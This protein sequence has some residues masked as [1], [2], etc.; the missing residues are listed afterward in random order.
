MRS[1]ILLIGFCLV[2]FTGCGDGKSGKQMYGVYE[3]E[4]PPQKKMELPPPSPFEPPAQAKAE[5]AR[6]DASQAE[7]AYYAK[8]LGTVRV[9]FSGR[10][11]KMNAGGTETTT[12]YKVQDNLVLVDGAPLLYIADDNTLIFNGM[13]LRRKQ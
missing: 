1:A 6:F 12:R 2:A 8:T 11:L 4:T 7:L 9:E 5:Q 13:T 10:V 3:T